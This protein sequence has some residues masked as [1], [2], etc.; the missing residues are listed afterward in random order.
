[1]ARKTKLMEVSDVGGEGL[2]GNTRYIDTTLYMICDMAEGAFGAD[3]IEAVA[4]EILYT[5]TSMSRKP[6]LNFLVN[7]F[8]ADHVIKSLALANQTAI[9]KDMGALKHLNDETQADYFL[10]FI[11]IEKNARNTKFEPAAKELQKILFGHSSETPFPVCQGIVDF[12][13]HNNDDVGLYLLI[14]KLSTF[15]KMRAKEDLRD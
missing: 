2:Y 3:F 15:I 14:K 13:K 1:M 8:L 12:F 4:D 7:T 10:A 6:I 11:E 9:A 5:Q